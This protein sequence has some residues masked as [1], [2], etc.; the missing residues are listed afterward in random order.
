MRYFF[1]VDVVTIK[2]LTMGLV[3]FSPAIS[4]E[5]GSIFYIHVF[6]V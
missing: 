2:Q 1:R 4:G 3:T 6:L 5:I